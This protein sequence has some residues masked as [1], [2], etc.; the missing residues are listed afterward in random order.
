MA[1]ELMAGLSIFNT[2]MGMAKA[3]KDIDNAVSRN[4]AV[5]ELQDQIFA[6]QSAQTT[7]I[8]R[9][10]DLEE[11]VRRF[12]TWETEKQRYELHER[13]PGRF[14]RKLKAGMENGEP[15]HEICAQCYEGRVKSILQ[16][17]VTQTGRYHM[18]T[19]NHCKTELN[20]SLAV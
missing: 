12:E 4:A 11:Q 17:R 2:M 13:K 14:T 19:C 8:A 9:I 18:L 7:L 6:A 16:S 20:L 10:G 1:G 5:I 3:L 15:P